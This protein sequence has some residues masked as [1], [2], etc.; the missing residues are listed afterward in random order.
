MLLYWQIGRDILDRQGREGWGAR[1]IERLAQ[2]LRKTF[3]DMKGFSPRN[4]KYMRAFAEAWP[5][6]SMVQG[7]L[8]QL[9][10]F[11]QQ[12]VG[13]SELPYRNLP[14]KLAMGDTLTSPAAYGPLAE[15]KAKPRIC[16]AGCCTI[17]LA[18]PL[19]RAPLLNLVPQPVAPMAIVAKA[20]V[21]A[22]LPGGYLQKRVQDKA[23]G[24]QNREVDEHL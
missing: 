11:V 10:W 9:P 5:D 22:R 18:P 21:R 20:Q 1:V 8:A 15:I 13:L 19:R 14:R 2:D 12:L 17:A 4:L 3:P 6:E 24:F 7:V 16:A 23:C